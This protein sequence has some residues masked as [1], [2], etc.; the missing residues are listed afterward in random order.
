MRK[1]LEDLEDKLTAAQDE[2]DEN[3]QKAE[4]LDKLNQS[5]R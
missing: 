1:A 3:R 5:Q 4:R 2:A